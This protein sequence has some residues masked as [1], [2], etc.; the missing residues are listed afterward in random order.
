MM[1]CVAETNRTLQTIYLAGFVVGV[2]IECSAAKADSPEEAL[3]QALAQKCPEA[4]WSHATMGAYEQPLAAVAR[5]LSPDQA[6]DLEKAA[7]DACR[8]VVMGEWCDNK[9]RI[10]HL[11]EVG[12]WR[13]RWLDRPQESGRNV[14]AYHSN[15]GTVAWRGWPDKRRP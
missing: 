9:G 5:R 8:G 12:I 2:L 13:R 11:A 14:V 7:R 4:R 10:Q 15:A 3:F 1:A 6:S